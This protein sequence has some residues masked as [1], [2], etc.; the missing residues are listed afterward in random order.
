MLAQGRCAPATGSRAPFGP[1]R[2]SGKARTCAVPPGQG[3]CGIASGPA[4]A[5][6]GSG[7]EIPWLVLSSITSL[8]ERLPESRSGG[9]PAGGRL[10]LNAM[11]GRPATQAYQE[12]SAVDKQ[13]ATAND[14][15]HHGGTTRNL[16]RNIIPGVSIATAIR[17]SLQRSDTPVGSGQ[18]AH[19]RYRLFARVPHPNSS[20]SLVMRCQPIDIAPHRRNHCSD[21]SMPARLG[22]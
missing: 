1:A 22:R 2:R 14:C 17:S 10:L 16:R 13:T 5:R 9:T 4:W 19:L 20:G 6:A 8:C 15:A 3:G 7:A 18:R 11:Q 12:L 21:R